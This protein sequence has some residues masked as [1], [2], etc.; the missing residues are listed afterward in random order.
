MAKDG[1]DFSGFRALPV[2]RLFF[3]TEQ[4]RA[5]NNPVKLMLNLD[6]LSLEKMEQLETEFNAIFDETFGVFR[7]IEEAAEDL[8]EE[9]AADAVTALAV[10]DEDT[11]ATAAPEAKALDLP[12]LE[13]FALEK[14]KFRFFVRA[15]AG[16]PGE[17]DP[18]N[19]FIHSWDVMKGN[20]AI[21][22]SY[23][24][25]LQ[26]PPHGLMDLY[27]FCVGEANNPTAQE[28]KA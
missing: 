8:P 11:A 10:V 21:P 28:K 3:P 14:S 20:K 1:F 5:D 9:T 7:K 24:S 19:R 2:E 4:A 18:N 27:R 23:E 17:K 26:M 12:K 22:I 13:L 25:F 16:A 6:F 15:L